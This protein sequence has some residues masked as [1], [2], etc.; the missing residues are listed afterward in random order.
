MPTQQ[1]FLHH[2]SPRSCT[3][4]NSQ[5][6]NRRFPQGQQLSPSGSANAGVI[7]RYSAASACDSPAL[8]KH[9]PRRSRK[10][11]VPR[12]SPTS[13]QYSIHLCCEAPLQVFSSGSVW[14]N[15]NGDVSLLNFL[16]L[17]RWG[18][19]EVD[20]R[21]Q[22]VAERWNKATA[23]GKAGLIKACICAMS[24]HQ[25]ISQLRD[26]FDGAYHPKGQLAYQRSSRQAAELIELGNSSNNRTRV[27][28]RQAKTRSH[29]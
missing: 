8:L 11:P 3:P 18:R 24:T 12:P 26:L 29:K 10:H 2:G 19:I 22:P 23:Q 25:I 1:Q 5:R 13:H 21:I 27:V 16:S 7:G 15:P 14:V 17:I 20:A 4:P 6:L 9:K 28:L